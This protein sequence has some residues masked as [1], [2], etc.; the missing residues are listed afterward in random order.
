M[1]PFLKGAIVSLLWLGC[2]SIRPPTSRAQTQTPTQAFTEAADA[3]VGA[4]EPERVL[5]TGSYIPI[6]TAEAE[7]A[8]PVTVE[9]ALQIIKSG[10]QTPAEGLRQL[11]SFIGATATE[12]DSNGGNGAAFV[13]LRAL[14][15]GN[16][17]TLINGRRA[18][19]FRDINAVGLGAVNRVEILKDGA[20]AIYGSDAVAGVVNFVLLDGPGA[21][22]YNGAEI[23]F[24]YGNTTE[25]DAHVIQL[26]VNTGYTSKDQRFSAVFSFNYYDRQTIYARDRNGSTRSG[27]ANQITLGGGNG[28]S[29][30]LPGRIDL[31]GQPPGLGGRTPI[32]PTQLISAGGANTRIFNLQ[33]G[34]G[35][36]FRAYTPA[37]P[38][39]EKIAYYGAFS[40]KLFGNNS[41]ILYGDMM[42]T[43]TRQDN[44]LAPSPLSS[45]S[46]FGLMGAGGTPA[47]GRAAVA[48][49]PFNPFGTFRAPGGDVRPLTINARYRLE[50]ESGNRRIGYDARYYRFEGGLRGEFNFKGNILGSMNYDLG[51]V[52]EQYKQIDTDN[53]DALFSGLL[54][55]YLPNTQASRDTLARLFTGSRLAFGL[56]MNQQ[57]GGTFNP[58]IGYAAPR[59][60]TAP[61]YIQ[62][63]YGV[64]GVVGPAIPNGTAA[65]DNFAAVQ[66][67][68]Y[69]ANNTTFNTAQLYDFRLG[70]TLMPNL[71][72]G[73]FSVVVGG[74]YRTESQKVQPDPIQSVDPVT[75]VG[76]ALGFNSLIPADYKS[77]TFSTFVELSIPA[78]TPA[79][80]I[81]LVYALDFTAAIRWEQYTNTGQD[82][83]FV[84]PVTGVVNG[85]VVNLTGNNG[86][87]PRFTMRWQ[88]YQD[89]TFRASYGKSFAQPNFGQL[90]APNTLNFPAL[91]DPLTAQIEQPASGVF[92]RGNTNLLPE[93]S[94]TYTAGLVF[95]PKQLRGFTISVDFYQI[96]T[97]HL[98]VD[99]GS[100]AQFMLTANGRSGGR[101]FAIDAVQA[102]GGVFGVYRPSPGEFPDQ[103]NAGYGNVGTRFVEGIDV[104]VIYEWVTTSA[105]KFTFTLGYNHFF[106]YN[107]DSTIGNS[108][109]RF[110]G[111]N[112]NSIPLVPGAVP[113]NKGFF[114]VEWQ[115]RGFYAGAT[116]NY[117]GDY[118]N[119]GGAL[120]NGRNS[121]DGS[122]TAPINSD[123]ANP[124]YF[125]HRY[126]GAYVTLDLQLSYSFKPPKSV[127]PVYAKDAKGVR[128]Q[129]AASNASTGNF[130]Q[131]ALWGTTIRAGVNNVFDRYPP[132]DAG[133][134]NDNYDTSTY[135]LRNRFWYVGINKRF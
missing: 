57:F 23:D 45:L 121:A 62:P 60:G 78:V 77:T 93:K 13:N 52:Y 135:T 125:Y 22:K 44:G 130:W 71:A 16:T 38:A 33:V 12:N 87:T 94:D 73:G 124:Q 133:A 67:S 47:Q 131:K 54:G 55:Q 132:Y 80:K 74:E 42:Y 15:A 36:N 48:S 91:F 104:T 103:I 110:V 20:S 49:S 65:Y 112:F 111:G 120:A 39:Q 24:L 70:A 35:F 53:G 119:D 8:L 108:P 89:L 129:V 17:L 4:S 37:I 5:V 105:G 19:G 113:Y 2:F 117:V 25:K 84:D 82:P 18:F 95:T 34:D 26:W 59:S 30:T 106:Y 72:Q 128:T 85:P 81:P 90:F 21:P 102:A 9:T 118:L 99:P 50:D 61:V 100:E 69:T 56:R 134:F 28:N 116:V 3:T 122:D 7:G 64:G 76:D 10:A 75:G 83:F 97:Q 92:Q 66:R 98:I 14:G 27:E 41:A 126:S 43:E 11:P 1:S 46:N 40:Y 114:R 107:V 29:G 68:L 96:I 32:D 79:M 123:I 109:T 115:Y 51:V 6:P 101:A 88:P 63:A 58:F 127:D 86:G 31:G